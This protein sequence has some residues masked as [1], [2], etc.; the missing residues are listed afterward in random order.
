MKKIG[1][2]AE[3]NPFHNGHK[4]LINQIKKQFPNCFLV[5]VLSDDY[6]QRGEITVAPYEERKKIALKNGANK[7][8]R[9]DLLSSTQAAHIFAKGAIDLLVEEKIDILCFGVSD[10]EANIDKYINSV[11]AINQKLNEY[12]SLIKTYLN[13]GFSYPYSSYEALKD[14]IKSVDDIPSDILG[15][16][17]TKYI[18][19]NNLNI[20]PMCFKRSINSNSNIPFGKYATASYIRKLIYEKKDYSLYTDMVIK[21]PIKKI[22]DYYNKFQEIVFVSTIDELS[23]IML[24]SEGMENLFKKNIFAKTYDEF[25]NLCISK[26]Y[27]KSRIKRA[28][29][30][31]ILNIKK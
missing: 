3:F 29:L 12:N 31:T 19:N 16:E 1:L 2:I 9:L 26:R 24:M 21:S 6:N 14:I 17:Y 10:N 5:I 7:V 22:E 23:Q 18:I 27:T 28:I 11:Y 4:Y 13:K 15:L 8:I 25:V 20:Q 30:Y